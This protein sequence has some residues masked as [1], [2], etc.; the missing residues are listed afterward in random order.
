MN[1]NS[2]SIIRI[3]NRHSTPDT[4]RGSFIQ[5]NRFVCLTE[6][7]KELK[8]ICEEDTELSTDDIKFVLRPFLFYCCNKYSMISET[9]IDDIINEYLKIN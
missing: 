9:Q 8:N 2:S 5:E 7:I 3:L 4:I 6:D 1:F